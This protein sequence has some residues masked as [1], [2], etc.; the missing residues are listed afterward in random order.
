MPYGVLNLI[1]TSCNDTVLKVGV[2]QGGIWRGEGSLSIRQNV[3]I[4]LH[5][6][7]ALSRQRNEL[8]SYFLFIF[9]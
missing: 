7:T 1:R 8:K 5:N 9:M 4:S 2:C 6:L 3:K